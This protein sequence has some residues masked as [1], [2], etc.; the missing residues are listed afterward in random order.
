VYGKIFDSIYDG[1]LYGHWEAIVTMQQLIVLADA[2]GIVDMTPQAIA[3]R[4][5]IPLHIITKGLKVLSEPDPYSRTPGED[6]RRIVTIDA[7]RPWGW[8]LVNH[9]KYKAMRD[10]DQKREA[11]RARI[12]EKR[13]KNN[14]V[15]IESQSVADVAHAYADAYADKNKEEVAV[16]P[17]WL[18]LEAWKAWLEVRR[19]NKAPNTPRALKLALGE[20]ELLRSQGYDPATVLDQSTLKGWKSLY[21]PKDGLLSEKKEP[22]GKICDYCEALASGS[23]S[24][25][26]ACS[27]HWHMAMDNVAPMKAALQAVAVRGK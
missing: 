4:T 19:K 18:P 10:M 12:A 26:R 6:G 27:E 2:G 5:S 15:A 17:P 16:L 21:P 20:L 1:T 8:Q 22:G 24:G 13:S 23:V 3:A 7:H 14:D 11:D 25:R 9:A